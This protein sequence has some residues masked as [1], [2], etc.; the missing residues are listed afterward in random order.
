[1]CGAQGGICRVPQLVVFVI[2]PMTS[3]PPPP[4]YKPTNVLT[5]MPTEFNI[6]DSN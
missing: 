6:G 2:K 1:M 4:S 3:Q 5:L